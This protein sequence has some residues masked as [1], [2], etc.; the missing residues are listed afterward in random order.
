MKFDTSNNA[1]KIFKLTRNYLVDVENHIINFKNFCKNMVD[2]NYPSV[3]SQCYYSFFKD[4]ETMINLIRNN[5]HDRLFKLQQRYDDKER[6]SVLFPYEKQ[7]I[8]QYLNKFDFKKNCHKKCGCMYAEKILKDGKEIVTIGFSICND[9]DEFSKNIALNLAKKRAREYPTR[10]DIRVA[11]RPEKYPTNDTLR[12]P[13]KWMYEGEIAK[14]VKR[15]TRWFKN[16][17][18]IYPNNIDFVEFPKKKKKDKHELTGEKK[19][20]F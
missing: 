19:M 17:T 2:D 4:A 15:C 1:N 3:E 9:K 7:A 14:F 12:I 18:I 6:A 20:L 11:P 10:Y 5:I 13:Y 8:Y 16:E